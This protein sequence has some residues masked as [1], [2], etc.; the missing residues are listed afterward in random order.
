M[1]KSIRI[2]KKIKTILKKDKEPILLVR[3]EAYDIEKRKTKT[4]HYCGVFMAI[5]DDLGG[6]LWLKS[7]CKGTR[8]EKHSARMPREIE[9]TK[10]ISITHL[11]IQDLIDNT[12]KLAR[13]IYEIGQEALL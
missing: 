10:I 6:S 3:Y 7:K 1:D 5:N 13:I 9:T 12:N 11:N 2:I 8:D 4:I